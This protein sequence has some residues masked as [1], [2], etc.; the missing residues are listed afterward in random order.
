MAARGGCWYLVRKDSRGEKIASLADD[1]ANAA[2][3]FVESAASK[4]V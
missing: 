1:L 2:K 4:K 3:R